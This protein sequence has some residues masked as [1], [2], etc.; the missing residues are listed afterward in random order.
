MSIAAPGGVD[1]G[2]DTEE[3]FEFLKSRGS[4]I[5]TVPKDRWNAE[6][7]HG[8]QPGKIVTVS[9]VVPLHSI[10]SHLTFSLL[11]DQGWLHSEL[12]EY[13]LPFKSGMTVLIGFFRPS[14]TLKNSVSLPLKP[15]KCLVLRQL[16]K[17]YNIGSIGT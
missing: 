10:Q 14:R 7:Y 3:F 12:R 15:H 9:L 6:A 17:F 8:T 11:L 2:L 5:I 13:R 4:G 16:R 1:D